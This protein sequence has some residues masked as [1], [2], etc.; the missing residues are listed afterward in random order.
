METSGSGD[1]SMRASDAAA[2]QDAFDRQYCR[3]CCCIFAVLVGL[4]LVFGLSLTVCFGLRNSDTHCDDFAT[5]SMIVNTTEPAKPACCPQDS[6]WTRSCYDGWATF[7]FV[8]DGRTVVCDDLEVIAPDKSQA[9]VVYA[10]GT[11]YA[12]GSTYTLGFHTT[13]PS[14]CTLTTTCKRQCED[15][16]I[17]FIIPIAVAAVLLAVVI[18][19]CGGSAGR[20][21]AIGFCLGRALR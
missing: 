5:A 19:L 12:P 16:Y 14:Q 18:F 9:A 7:T 1:G 15:W 17:A 11:R 4:F 8:Y 21:C 20:G 13:Q 3:N 2:I 10:L 6:C